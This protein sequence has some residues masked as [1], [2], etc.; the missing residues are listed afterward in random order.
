MAAGIKPPPLCLDGRLGGK[1]TKI[2]PE[3]GKGGGF[4]SNSSDITSKELTIPGLSAANADDGNPEFAPDENCTKPLL[5]PTFPQ[6]HASG[7]TFHRPQNPMIIKKS[8][9]S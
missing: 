3:V 2:L 6:R 1:S 4:I 7:G 5:K 8:C 9:G